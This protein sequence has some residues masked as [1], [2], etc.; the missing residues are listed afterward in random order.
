MDIYLSTI[1]LFFL[2]AVF[3]QYSKDIRLKKLLLA[4]TY[5]VSVFVVGLRWETGTDWIPYIATFESASSFKRAI[6]ENIGM[7][8][9]YLLSNWIVRL[10]TSNYTVYLL[11]HASIFYY[12][13]LYGLVKYTKY[14][15]VAFMCI[16]S[17]S[18]GVVGSNRQL[19]ALAI[20]F[21]SL[22]WAYHRKP[23]FFLIVLLALQLHT[24]ALI[25]GIFYFFNK[26]IAVKWILVVIL[27]SAVIGL[28][29]IPKMLFGGISNIGASASDKVAAYMNGK[30]S[31]QLSILGVVRRIT[32]LGLF[33]YFRSNRERIVDYYNFFLNAFSFSLL[34]YLLFSSSLL[35]LVNRGSLYFNISQGI[36]LSYLLYTIKRPDTRLMFTLILFLLCIALM[37]QSISSYPDEFDPYKGIWYNQ[38][39]RRII[40]IG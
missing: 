36:L 11:L 8:K 32:L 16:F 1:F 3:E 24:T 27:I 12:C 33:L 31:S 28:T 22:T 15:Q 30:A 10:F 37:Y 13:I 25:S 35:I 14:P 9:G 17:E 7:E 34:I 40:N 38:D 21:Y 18:L 5:L 6:A 20:I 29:P 4:L 26:H 2:F 23:K 39:F 19:L